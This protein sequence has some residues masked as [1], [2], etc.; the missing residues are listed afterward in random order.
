MSR[1]TH[2]LPSPVQS[3]PIPEVENHTPWPSQYFQHVDPNGEAFHV[4]VTRISYSLRGMDFAQLTAPTPALLAPEDQLALREADEYLGDVN[5]S[6]VIQESDFAPYKPKCDVL[7]VNAKAYTPDGKPAQR[8]AAGFRFGTQFGNQIEKKFVVTGPRQF[9]RS[10][11]SL[12]TLAPCEPE[13]VAS[14]P[15]CYELAFGGPALIAH[16]AQLESWVEHSVLQANAQQRQASSAVKNDANKLGQLGQV[17]LDAMPEFYPTNPIGS[18]RQPQ[19]IADLEREM[20]QLAEHANTCGAESG[21]SAQILDKTHERNLHKSP[22][23]A[24]QVEA[25]EQPYNGEQQT[26][27]VIGVGPIGRWWH[28]RI[29]LAGTHDAAWKATQWP[30]SPLDH[31]YRYWN[32]APEDQQID[33]PQGGEEVTLVN[34]TPP[35][36]PLAVGPNAG[37]RPTVRFAL[38]KQDL[39]LLVRLEVGAMLFAPMHIDTVIIDFATGTLSIVRR[40]TISAKAPVRKLELGTWPPGTTMQLGSQAQQNAASEFAKEKHAADRVKKAGARHGR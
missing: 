13:A 3:A 32:C 26:Y 1:P 18:G 35:L 21:I 31:D 23:S 38:P 17:L 29:T 25:F 36:A 9:E 20:T 24:P 27:P 30:K 12:G 2:V 11:S 14:V 40:A 33:Y 15:L 10:L 6:S 4:M 7:L 39:Q 8:W 16:D 19:L 37:Q 5:V 22:Y 28:P 34:L